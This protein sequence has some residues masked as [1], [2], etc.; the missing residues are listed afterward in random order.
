MLADR[1]DPTP[2]I[3]C[4]MPEWEL[5]FGNGPRAQ[6]EALYRALADATG[7]QVFSDSM[8]PTGNPRD[9]FYRDITLTAERPDGQLRI[10]MELREQTGGPGD[11]IWILSSELRG[12]NYAIKRAAYHLLRDALGKLD[13]VDETIAKNPAAIV[14]DAEAAGNTV[15]ASQMRAEITARLVENARTNTDSRIVL[16]SPRADL[17]TVLAAYPHPET[18]TRITIANGRLRTLPAA[19]ARFVN[20]DTLSVGEDEIDASLVRGAAFPTVKTLVLGRTAIRRLTRD[21]L[22]GF[23]ALEELTLHESKLE[24]LDAD[25]VEVCPNLRSVLFART[26]LAADPAKLA[27]LH[28]RWKQVVFE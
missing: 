1:T 9:G 11:Q 7:G 27:A 14:D 19:L 26:P 5:A 28:A 12:T 8:E 17:A 10:A 2:D 18:I 3:L 20:L 24:D 16:R 21:D 25:I 4:L 13:Y 22:A 6:L 23:P 15:L